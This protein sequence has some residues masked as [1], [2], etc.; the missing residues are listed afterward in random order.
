M[1]KIIPVILAG[2]VGSR[3]WPLSRED[4]PKQFLRLVSDRTMLQDTL[5]R[6]TEQE[7]FEAPAVVCHGRYAD[8]VKAQAAEV[9]VE[10]GALILEPAARNSAPAI[11]AAAAH[12]ERVAPGSAVLISPA[13]HLITDCARFHDAVREA[14]AIARTGRL[15]TF[16]I[17]PDRPETGY[18]YIKAGA[19]LGDA[20]GC[21]VAAFVEKPELATAE[22]YLASGDYSWNSGM[23]L[24][25][26]EDMLRE[27]RHHQLRLSDAV[28]AALDHAIRKERDIWLDPGFFEQAPS[29]SIDY[30][31]MEKTDRAA[32]ATARFGWSDIGAWDAL[33]GQLSADGEGNT[34]LGDAVL[35]NA[36]NV[37]C[38]SDGP[39]IAAIGV[40]DL[41][42]VATEDAVM[43]TRKDC[44]QK[45]KDAFNEHKAW[46]ESRPAPAAKASDA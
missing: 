45:V 35:I 16:G 19:P 26:C 5:L 17:A 42:I 28:D 29:I 41:V 11:A 21:E 13:D 15:A 33:S 9:G 46:A 30:A 18:G 8:V 43:V 25:R 39:F 37:Y 12:F 14:N 20:P 27:L 2:G 40:E 10:L 44:C 3:L 7:L 6:V 4:R 36:K 34:Q 32:V 1:S 24:F 31:V 22:G 38:R 23:F